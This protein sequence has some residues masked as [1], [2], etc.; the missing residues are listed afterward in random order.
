MIW[1]RVRR[2]AAYEKIHSLLLYLASQV[3]AQ[4]VAVVRGLL[5]PNL[6]G[7]AGYGLVATV[8]AVDRYT[9]Y[10]S[11][12]VHYYVLNRLP[13]IDDSERRR[14]VLATVHAFTVMTSLIAAV[15]FCGVAL[16]QR[17]SLP[18]I[19]VMGVA[20]LAL[21]PLA[22]GVWRLHQS[23]LRV[24]GRIPLLTRLS[25]AQSIVS[26]ALLIGLTWAAG[27]TG[28][29]AAQLLTALVVLAL[30][31]W[32]SPCRFGFALDRTLLRTAL[33]F[34]IP[35]FVVS[36]LLVTLV[37]TVD[38]F[39]IAHHLGIPA[40]GRFAW[41]VAMVSLLLIWTNALTTVYSTPVIRAVHADGARR[42]DGLRF[43][44]R[45]LL[46]NCLVFAGLAT[47]VYV[48]LPVIARVVFPGFEAAVGTARLLVVS[49]YYENISVLGLFVVTA[50]NRFN[51]YLVALAVLV[52]I[53]LP[54]AWWLA[55][56]GVA[57]IAGLAIAR[58]SVK[59]HVVLDLGLRDA[60][61]RARQILYC[62]GL[63]AL[64][65]LPVF[66]GWLVD[67][68]DMTVSRRNFWVFA[69]ELFLVAAMMALGFGGLFYIVQRRYGLFEVLWR[70]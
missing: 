41:G 57:W 15:V 40:V 46:A 23:V 49:A 26:S 53:S 27:V 31:A 66:V 44:R 37:D 35:V 48:F 5:L 20:T 63:Y 51:I 7:P 54:L 4:A 22:S 24:D 1:G 43:F 68:G 64:G 59:A 33:A 55:P 62:A 21:N 52:A 3:I 67:L 12:G 34:A 36:G 14:R 6:L 9:P 50:Q 8:N 25:N 42:D 17:G 16:S 10:V 11:V 2:I 29:F 60:V 30:V 56:N 70:A 28:T 47:V 38:V 39:A 13:V 61:G 69:P 58:R 18:A 65:V 19:A 45:L 32:A